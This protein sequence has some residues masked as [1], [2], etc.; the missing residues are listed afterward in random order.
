VVGSANVGFEK[1]SAGV[2]IGP[3]VRNSVFCGFL[4]DFDDAFEVL[5]FADKF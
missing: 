1:E 3:V 2:G 4:E 5:V